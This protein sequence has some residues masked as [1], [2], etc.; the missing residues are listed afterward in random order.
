MFAIL[1]R[2]NRPCARR[3]EN[4]GPEQFLENDQRLELWHMIDNR[5]VRAL[6][7]RDPTT[8]FARASRALVLV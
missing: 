4:N 6:Y 1:I 8:I 3:W 5:S 7:R 2:S